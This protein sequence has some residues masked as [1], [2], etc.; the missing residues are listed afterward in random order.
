MKKFYG[1]IWLLLFSLLLSACNGGK[2]E[3]QTTEEV[4]TSREIVL[5]ENG[6]AALQIIVPDR[7]SDKITDAAEKLKKKLKEVTGVLFQTKT[8][9][10]RNNEILASERE[11][12]IGSCKRQDSVDVLKG[13]KYRDY[14]LVAT[15]SNLLLAGYE[16]MKIVSAVNAMIDRLTAENVT[17]VNGKAILK[18][19]KDEFYSSD[20]YKLE[21]ITLG[22]VAISEY[23]IVFPSGGNAA[24]YEEY[25]LELQKSIGKACGSALQVVPDTYEASTYEIL[26]GEVNRPETK[27]YYT[28]SEAANA[29]EYGL[30]LAGSKLLVVGGGYFSVG[31]GVDLLTSA[32]SDL[33]APTLDPIPQTKKF[34]VENPPAASAG[35]RIMSYNIL[36]DL[37][38]WA[39]AHI[40][41]SAEIR[42]EFLAG[43]V[44]AYQPD[45][46]ALQEV[47]SG[48][49]AV[50]AGLF[51]EQ[52]EFVQLKLT[53]GKTNGCPLMYNKAKLELIASGYEP[54]WTGD[55]AHLYKTVTWAVFENK[56]THERFI[57][58]GT[59]WATND[60]PEQ[61]LRE[62]ERMAN[63]GLRLQTEYNAP[64][65]AMGD[66][67][68]APS[69]QAYGIFANASG[70]SNATATV[71]VDH[72]FCTPSVSVLAKGTEQSSCFRFSSD[73]HYPI[74]IDVKLK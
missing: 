4:D 51:D 67:N 70:L 55:T 41:S 57:A 53:G 46:F 39:P 73:Y 66:F 56:T 12:I 59:H 31:Y 30:K 24:L 20:N 72:I 13:M 69:S 48:W 44:N 6:K 71:G 74:W 54:L 49:G 33:K 65:F 2:G 37:E 34:L 22:G 19:E 47:T 11:I 43:L 16:D 52:Y 68:S 42:G 26:I 29:L 1:I 17:T 27:D 25:A 60:Q 10:S 32:I 62:A 58:M 36:A 40:H 23:R 64:V 35:Y 28:S 7:A 8:D 38:G 18:W 63:L 9:Y 15:D 5:T 50:F 45:V 61:Q 21:S 14:A 3:E